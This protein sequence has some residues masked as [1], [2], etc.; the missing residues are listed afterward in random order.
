MK[1]LVLAPGKSSETTR[2]I[3]KES[4]KLFSS[5]DLVPIREVIIGA[6][7]DLGIYYK[8]KNLSKYDYLLPRIDSKR[9][10][11]G[12]HI[13]KFFDNI[14]MKKPFSAN[15]VLMAHNKFSTIYELKMA[16]LPVPDTYYT[17]S[18]DSASSLIKKM[19]YPAV[20][21]LVSSFGGK[22]VMFAES[23][24]TGKSIVQTLDLLNQDL[25][26]EDFIENPGEDIRVFIIG[27]EY[28]S[29]K[30]IAK[31]GER[32]ANVKAGGR[33]VSFKPT[34]EQLEVSR[35]AAEILGAKVCAVDIVESKDGP[36]I[37]E[38]NIN[39]G[40]VGISKA[41]GDNVAQK[42]AKFCYEEA[43]K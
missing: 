30:R 4:K 20:I 26:V 24:K 23:E 40:I 14:G 15:S 18:Q 10:S 22:G 37:I 32:R 1:L 38:L 8:T 39:P 27:D 25:M 35:K 12:Y 16:G 7:K 31:K 34:D 3:I 17:T 21:K 2:M 43:K 29:M 36:Q 41:T 6:G 5:V 42:I 19:N 33:T 11:F 9:A 28:V 13:I